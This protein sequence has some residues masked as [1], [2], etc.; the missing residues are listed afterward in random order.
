MHKGDKQ[1]RSMDAGDYQEIRQL[2]DDYLRMYATRDDLLTTHFSEDFSGFTGG[3]DFLVKKRE[4]WVTITRQDFAQVKEAIRLELKDVSIQSLSDTIAVATSFF[5]IHLPIKDHILSRETA[6]LVLIYRK[7]SAGWKICHS[8]ISIPYHLVREGEVYPLKELTERN[9]NLEVLIEERSHQL[10]V[11]NENLLRKNAELAI[12]IAERKQTEAALHRSEGLYRSILK[13][14]PDNITIA[15]RE[16]R[17]VMVSPVAFTMFASKPDEPF[18]GCAVTDYIVP[19]DRARAMAQIAQ[20]RQ[21]IVTGP[22]EY[23]GLR[24]NGSTF[25]IEVNSEFIRDTEGLP[26][27]L[28]VI[29]RDITE[30]KRAEEEREKLES[31]NRQLQKS[32][33][34]GRMAGAIAHHFNNQLQAVMMSLDLALQDLTRTAGGPVELLNK[35]MAS[36]HKAAE[37]SSLMLTYLGQATARRLSLD[38]SEA[39]RYGL[40]I[41][42]AAAPKNVVIETD[43]LIHGPTILGNANQIQQA[44]TNLI[45]NAWEACG[46][47]QGTIRLTVKMVSAKEIPA[48]NRFPV[49]S[50]IQESAHAC[51]EVADTGCGIAATEIEKLFDP[52]FTSKFTGRGLGL[53][54]VL[55]IVRAHYGVVTVASEPGQGSVFQ[56]FLPVSAGTV[57][58][59]Q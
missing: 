46:D 39:C 31:Q 8:G 50:K 53:A 32:E 12:E 21:G 25:A 48:A 56:V 16:G 10:S 11:A 44:L 36:A 5:A 59:I 33:S 7:E 38:L 47:E 40:P 1:A 3:G 20:K 17:I 23:R 26:T 24:R 35:A 42:M 37:V 52:F 30:R 2:L 28:V 4:E 15:D 18:M 45:T 58:G 41:L 51:L 55:G 54:V 14:S 9:Q 43:L 57:A 6:R 34:L 22:T 49:G 27:G 29:V 19:E 13:A